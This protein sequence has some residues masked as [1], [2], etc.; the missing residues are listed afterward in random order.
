MIKALYSQVAF[1]FADIP[2]RSFNESCETLALVGRHALAESAVRSA[3]GLTSQLRRP[4]VAGG[5]VALPGSH[6]LLVGATGLGALWTAE[7]PCVLV[8][9][10]ALMAGTGAIQ[11]TPAVLASNGTGVDAGAIFVADKLGEALAVSRTAAKSISAIVRRR[12]GAI[13]NTVLGVHIPPV[14][15]ATDLYAMVVYR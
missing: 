6:T 3:D 7:L 9:D 14:T 11:I 2:V 12:Y 15:H 8:Q 5:A 13:R 10:K 1:S 4:P